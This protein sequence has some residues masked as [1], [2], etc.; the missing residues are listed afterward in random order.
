[1]FGISYL[2]QVTIRQRDNYIS[3]ETIEERKKREKKG[4]QFILS[5]A[6]IFW[7]K[8]GE[9]SCKTNKKSWVKK[10]LSVYKT[11]IYFITSY[12]GDTFV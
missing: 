5:L 1:M 12:F 3:M 7:E 8:K 9:K 10:F 6:K 11:P 2:F 4:K